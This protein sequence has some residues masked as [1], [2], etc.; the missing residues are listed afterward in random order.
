M[1]RNEKFSLCEMLIG[2]GIVIMMFG[3]IAGIIIT[4]IGGNSWELMQGSPKIMLAFQIDQLTTWFGLMLTI[5]ASV[6]WNVID[7][8]SK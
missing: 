1:S 4:A 2:L 6:A 5:V 7:K 3:F 8:K